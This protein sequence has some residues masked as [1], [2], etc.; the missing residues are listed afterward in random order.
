MKQLALIAGATGDFGKEIVKK[1][2]ERGLKII[3][4]GRN[5]EELNRLSEDD[6]NIIA[7]QADISK[8]SAIE[9]IKSACKETVKLVINCAGVAVAGGVKD[10]DLAAM[11]DAVNIKVGGLLRMVRAADSNLEKHS[12]IIAIAGHYGLEPTEYAATAGIA[13]AA[14][15]NVSRQL[16]L[17]YGERGVTS[18]VIAPGPADTSRL[19]KVALN[20]AARDGKALEEVLDEMADESSLGEF[21]TPQQ[22][23]W[24]VSILIDNEADAMTGSTLMLDVGRRRGLP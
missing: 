2:L 17:A 24:A 21:T 7:C 4:I 20:R 15:I 18:H 11:N 22:V 10:A 16:S 1:L 8:D 9:I 12:R 3:A 19:R 5:L 14:L 13:N 6:K 23:A